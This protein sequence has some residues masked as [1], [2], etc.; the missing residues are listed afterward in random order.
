MYENRVLLCKVVRSPKKSWRHRKCASGRLEARSLL[1]AGGAAAT[2][3]YHSTE[4][5]LGS[6]AAWNELYPAY[7]PAM[8]TQ[9]YGFNQV[10]FQGKSGAISGKGNGQTI[11]IVD[12]YD[13]PNILKDADTFS[14]TFALP[15]FNTTGGPTFTKMNQKGTSVLPTKDS[16]GWSTEI[17]LDVSG[18]TQSRRWPTSSW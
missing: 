5:R 11:A 8:V 14:T 1:S 2:V 13:D 16:T 3:Y 17:A 6:A 18:P 12:A 4:I 9:A 7:S 15:K 10:G